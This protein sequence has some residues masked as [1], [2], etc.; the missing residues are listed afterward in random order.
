MKSS[1][2]R[3]GQAGGITGRLLRTIVVLGLLLAVDGFLTQ[4]ALQG[5]WQMDMTDQAEAHLST[6]MEKSAAPSK[7]GSAFAGLR[8]ALRKGMSRAGGALLRGAVTQVQVQVTGSEFKVTQGSGEM[9]AAALIALASE[10]QPQSTECSKGRLRAVFPLVLATCITQG[11][12]MH[13]WLL[14]RGWP[15]EKLKLLPLS[16]TGRQIRDLAEELKAKGGGTEVK[17]PDPEVREAIKDI[18]T[19]RFNKVPAAQ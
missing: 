15:S 19:L 12:D 18:F 8:N 6:L 11:E 13:E 10:E 2:S 1:R 4:R 14:M 17:L 7:D 3:S 5:T 9:V 16:L